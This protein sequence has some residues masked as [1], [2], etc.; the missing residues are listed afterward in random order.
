MIRPTTYHEGVELIRKSSPES[1]TLLTPE[2]VDFVATLERE[3]GER[4]LKILRKRAELQQKLNS[5]MLPNFLPS[6]K[7]IRN[8]YWRVAPCPPDLLDRRVEITGPTDRKTI[9]N[10]LNSGAR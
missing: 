9:I 8:G 5:G 10:G 3:F 6:T 7:E 2:A 4:R 1:E